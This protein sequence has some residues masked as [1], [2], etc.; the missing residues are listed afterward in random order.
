MKKIVLKEMTNYVGKM[1]LEKLEEQIKEAYKRGIKRVEI[2]VSGVPLR[3]DFSVEVARIQDTYNC[4]FIGLSEKEEMVDAI[5]S[6]GYF[7]K[8]SLGAVEY[9]KK[10]RRLVEMSDFPLMIKDNR[11]KGDELIVYNIIQPIRFDKQYFHYNIIKPYLL[12]PSELEKAM[13][14]GVNIWDKSQTHLGD[15]AGKNQGFRFAN[16]ETERTILDI[17][18]EIIEG[19]APTFYND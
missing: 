1:T 12:E 5:V 13:L 3:K 6:T 4:T 15:I 16:T 9:G 17:F 14:E 19:T 7:I 2:D 8:E 18:T 11:L 10:F